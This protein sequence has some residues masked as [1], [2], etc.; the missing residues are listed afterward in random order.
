MIKFSL[1]SSENKLVTLLK[2]YFVKV[3]NLLFVALDIKQAILNYG[4]NKTKI[5]ERKEEIEY[6]NG[7]MEIIENSDEQL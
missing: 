1:I 2:I 5:K 7:I 6:Y 4:N 3:S